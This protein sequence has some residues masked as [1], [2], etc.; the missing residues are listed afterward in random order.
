MPHN[1]KKLA[2][3]RG[4]QTVDLVIETVN[5]LGSIKNAAT[6]FGV[7]ENAIYWHINHHNLMI[8]IADKRT[9]LVKRES[10]N[11]EHTP[12]RKKRNKETANKGE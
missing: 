10:L 1:I 7:H 9:S 3:A 2:K 11:H 4:M 12:S 6:E 8:V 5:R